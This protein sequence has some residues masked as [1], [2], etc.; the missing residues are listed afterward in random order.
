[1]KFNKIIISVLFFVLAFG[2]STTVAKDQPGGQPFAAVWEAI[3]DLRTTLGG[4]VNLQDRVDELE[5]QVD[6]LEGRIDELEGICADCCDP[7]CEPSDE[8]CDGLDNDCD[9]A[10]D[11]ELSQSCYTGNPATRNVGVCQD[12]NQ[13]CADGDWGDCID[14]VL[15]SDEICDGLDNDCNGEIDDNPE[16]D[17]VDLDDPDTWD[18]RVEMEYGSYMILDDVL[19]CEKTYNLG[20]VGLK[21]DNSNLDLT[22]DCNNATLV[23]GGK[24]PGTTSAISVIC[25]NSVCTS[26]VTV[27]NC[28]VENYN[29]GIR[30]IYADETTI[31]N[32][33]V[34]NCNAGIMLSGAENCVVE[35]NEVSGMT[36][37][38]IILD[39]HYKGRRSENNHIIN[40]T[41]NN[42]GHY[43]LKLYYSLYN[44]IVGNTI[45]GSGYYGIYIYEG[46]DND[47]YN[48]YFSNDDNV[49]FC[50]PAG[51]TNNWN[52]EKTAGTNIVGG[53]YLGGNYWSDYIGEDTDGDGL[54]DTLVP[55]IIKAC[56]LGGEQDE[57]ED[58][59]PLVE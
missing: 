47:I 24:I 42:N 48:N 39:L 21:V 44:T 59:L 22:I 50:S 10:I 16:C 6:S 9:D 43:G 40:N 12:G 38:G 26:N 28:N 15:P 41:M 29:G 53:P 1:M 55:H 11:E 45:M 37:E 46:L 36:R 5:S 8:I 13:V 32:N 52:T 31:I 4:L 19:L 35:N 54:G 49:Y 2:I 34:T 3:E 56:I 20:T 7:P 57:D 18:G 17:C 58:F 51:W 30:A 23:G 27:T 14:E 33:T 25:Y